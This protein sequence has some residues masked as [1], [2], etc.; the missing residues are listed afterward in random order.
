MCIFFF[1]LVI[2]TL[3]SLLLDICRAK[4][5]DFM[6]LGGVFAVTGDIVVTGL[7]DCSG[8]KCPSAGTKVPTF[9]IA[10]KK[11]YVSE[12]PTTKAP[13]T[14]TTTKKIGQTQY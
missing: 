13:K 9:D 5:G 7:S 8:S 12:K 14:T 2:I 11:L 3:I 6:V 1:Y 4:G 10:V